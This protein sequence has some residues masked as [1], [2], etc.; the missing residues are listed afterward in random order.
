M[1]PLTRLKDQITNPGTLRVMLIQIEH[2]SKWLQDNNLG[3]LEKVF[4]RLDSMEGKHLQKLQDEIYGGY[5]AYTKKLL[6]QQ[7]IS[8]LTARD[9]LRCVRRLFLACGF[10]LSDVVNNK[11]KL[12]NVYPMNSKQFP[13]IFDFREILGP[14]ARFGGIK[15]KA[16]VV[17]LLSSGIRIGEAVQL[18]WDD[19][20]FKADPVTIH[21]RP[22]ITKGKKERYTFMTKE[23]KQFLENLRNWYRDQGA[24]CGDRDFIFVSNTRSGGGWGPITSNAAYQLLHRIFNN[25]T[26]PK[27]KTRYKLF[28][29][30]L[31][32]VSKSWMIDSGIDSSIVNKILGHHDYMDKYHLIMGKKQYKAAEDQLTIFRTEVS[33]EEFTGGIDRLRRENEE[34]RGMLARF[35]ETE[36]KMEKLREELKVVQ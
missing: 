18:R 14:E 5:F 1:D 36:K 7:K 20:D 32:A 31:R 4:S 13:T 19:I 34:L 2:F 11:W 33:R 8:P 27:N 24:P 6:E 3:T 35:N 29:H 30:L 12:T 21:L 23:A 25:V 17:L 26:N 16:L 9:R 22:A 15:G 28:P 10:P